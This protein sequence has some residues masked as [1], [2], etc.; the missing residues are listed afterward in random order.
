MKKFAIAAVAAMFSLFVG[1]AGFAGT[2]NNNAAGL[3][4]DT[5]VPTDTTKVPVEPEKSPA[6]YISL[7]DTVVPADTAQAPT[8]PQKT[9]VFHVASNDT[10]VPADTVKA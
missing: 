4:N 3:V 9:P 5:V 7:A 1:G 6:L 2:S 8:E 10:V